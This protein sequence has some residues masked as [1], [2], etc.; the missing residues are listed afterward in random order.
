V[1]SPPRDGSAGQD[2]DGHQNGQAGN[3]QEQTVPAHRWCGPISRDKLPQVA[4]TNCRKPIQLVSIPTT[5]KIAR[6]I[7]R[8]SRLLFFMIVDISSLP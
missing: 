2:A 7:G 8:R 4:R 6:P 5:I 1:R 3:Q